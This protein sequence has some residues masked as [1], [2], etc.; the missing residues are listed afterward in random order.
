M[1]SLPHDRSR[2][3]ILPLSLQRGCYK[4]PG[5]GS[6]KSLMAKRTRSKAARPQALSTD[7]LAT[8]VYNKKR[9]LRFGTLVKDGWF[10]ATPGCAI[11]TQQSRCAQYFH[12]T[13][14]AGLCRS[15]A[16]GC[17]RKYHR[18]L[19][20]TRARRRG[21][22]YGFGKTGQFDLA[23]LARKYAGQSAT[24]AEVRAYIDGWSKW[25]NGACNLTPSSTSP[26]TKNCWISP[27]RSLRTKRAP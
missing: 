25:S 19:S 6:A 1:A 5:T 21:I 12:V 26:S 17:R 10:S 11:R 9:K 22:R 2:S 15:D 3:S 14:E 13:F 24:P 16:R 23:A 20:D 7:G 4:A 8:S 18:D 27:R